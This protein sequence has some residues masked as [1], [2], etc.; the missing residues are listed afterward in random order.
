ML[1]RAT[2]VSALFLAAAF[3][4]LPSAPAAAQDGRGLSFVAPT[5]EPVHTSPVC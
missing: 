5:A 1:V 4:V 2:A 3:P